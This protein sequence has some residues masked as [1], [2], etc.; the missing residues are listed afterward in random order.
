MP[1]HTAISANE[2]AHFAKLASSWWDSTGPQRILHKMNLL[3]MDFINKTVKTHLPLDRSATSDFSREGKPIEGPFIPGW[4]H[5]LLPKE[6]SEK[7]DTD[8]QDATWKHWNQLKLNCLDIGCG[9]GLLTESLAR[10]KNVEGVKGIDMTPE[11]LE[12]AKAHALL[13]PIVAGKV[14]YELTAL[15]NVHGEYDIVTCMEMLEHVEYPA[16]VLQKAMSLVKP[17]G[18]LFLSTINRD[19]ISW[20]TTI[21]MGEHMLRIVP[22][23]THTYEKYIKEGEIRDVV[24]RQQ[25]YNVVD[26]EGLAYLPLKGWFCTGKPEIGNYIMAI[27]RKSR[28]TR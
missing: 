21:F 20:F 26:S 11:V 2:A 19:A 15:E 5:R 9:G 27:Q 4:N 14:S 16:L 12:V 7:I 1:P 22:V 10:L 18:Y 28:E 13:D 17:G 6:I 25:G 23:G 3:R 8:L 24:E